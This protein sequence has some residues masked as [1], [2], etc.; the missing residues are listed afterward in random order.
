MVP[1]HLYAQQR[2]LGQMRKTLAGFINHVIHCKWVKSLFYSVPETKTHWAEYV[3]V[4]QSTL[5]SEFLSALSRLH[6][7]LWTSDV[8]LQYNVQRWID[9]LTTAMVKTK[10]HRI[11]SVRVIVH[12]LPRLPLHWRT[13]AKWDLGLSETFLFCI[14]ALVSG[15]R[16]LKCVIGLKNMA[17]K[18][19]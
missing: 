2:P 17:P 9:Q 4:V 18:H 3:G 16:S 13:Y 7:H 1:S 8:N 14:R 19:I 15:G 11:V 10:V 5:R 12:C 6:R